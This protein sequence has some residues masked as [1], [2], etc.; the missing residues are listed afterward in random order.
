M[1]VA[2]RQVKDTK[3]HPISDGSRYNFEPVF[4]GFEKVVGHFYF[5][6][7]TMRLVITHSV[8]WK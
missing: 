8:V 1:V 5:S 7:V 4:R 2:C 3:K 6:I